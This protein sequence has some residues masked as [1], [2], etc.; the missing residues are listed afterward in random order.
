MRVRPLTERQPV[1]GHRAVE[2]A[3]LQMN[4]PLDV[5]RR[6]RFVVESVPRRFR[7]GPGDQGEGV[8]PF[9]AAPLDV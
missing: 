6:G 4:G 1:H 3:S 2:V 8:V 9:G 5:A 7:E